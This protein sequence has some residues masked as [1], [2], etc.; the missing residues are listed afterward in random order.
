VSF[1]ARAAVTSA[2]QRY[3]IVVTVP[4][5]APRCGYR[6][7]L[8]LNV[9]ISDGAHVSRELP[10]N[11]CSGV[12]HGSVLYT[13]GQRSSHGLWFDVRGRTIPVGGFSVRVP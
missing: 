1:I 2:R 5:T 10:T 12:F 13:Y 4:G 9:N 8:P 7:G 11:G 6:I 3:E